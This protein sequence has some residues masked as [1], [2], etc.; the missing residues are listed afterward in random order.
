[1]KQPL[2]PAATLLLGSVWPAQAA[3][4]ALDNFNTRTVGNLAGQGTW[5][6]S[7]TTAGAVLVDPTNSINKIMR[8]S[9]QAGVGMPLPA[10]ITNSSTSATLFFRMRLNSTVNDTSFGLSDVAATNAGVNTFGNFEVQA[11]ASNINLRGRDAG[12]TVNSTLNFTSSNWYKIWLVVNNSTDSYRIFYKIDTAPAADPPT[13]FVATDGTFNFRN[14]VA[15]NSLV[16]LQFTSNSTST[17]LYFDDFYID[18]AAQNMD[19]PTFVANPD[20]DG[21]GLQDAWEIFYFGNLS[22]APGDDTEG[23]TGDGLTNLEEQAKGT[24][25]TLADTD[26]DGLSDGAEDHGTL[27]TAFGNAPTSPTNPDSDGDGLTD[28]QEI[29]GTL[30]TGFANA[31]SNPNAVD[32]D[33]DGISDYDETVYATNPSNV[34]STPKLYSLIGPAKRNGS[35]ELLGGVTGSVATAAHWDTDP[36]GDVDNWTLWPGIS[37]ATAG[38]TDDTQNPTNGIRRT[39][40]DINNAAYN[41]TTYQAKEGDVI[42]VTWDHLISS[43]GTGNHT[44][45]VVYDDGAGTIVQ[46]TPT[47]TVS[48]APGTVNKLIYKVPAGSPL[49]GKKIGVGIKAFANDQRIDNVVMT[50]V[51]GDSDGDGLADFWED[52]YFGNN[53]DNPTP[54]E[55]ALQNGSGDPDGDGYNN[56]AEETV[57]SA[58]NN[59]GSNPG[60]TDSDGLADEWEISNAGNLTTLSGGGADAD[61]DFATDEQEE[62]AHSNPLVAGDFPDTDSDGLNDGWETFYFGNLATGNVDSDSDG[63]SNSAEMLAGSSPTDPAWT[64]QKAVLKHRWSFTGNLNDSVGTSNAQ[65]VDADA[66]PATGGGSSL[67]ASSVTLA[68]GLSTQSDYIDL[69]ANLLQGKKTPVTIELWA[70]QNSVQNWGRIFD[71]NNNT[72]N[73]YLM[74]AWTAGVNPAADSVEWKDTTLFTRANTLAPYTLGTQY[75]IVMTIVPAVNTAGEMAAGSRVS[76]YAAPAGASSPLGLLQ[77]N[78]DVPHHLFTFNDLHNWLGRSIA[79]TDNT[80]NA[81]YDE[82]RIWDGALSSREA[83]TAQAAGPDAA[84]LTADT[85]GDTLPDA[86]EIAFFGNLSKTA[87]DDSDGDGSSNAAELAAGSLPNNPASKPGDADGDGLGDTW[88]FTNF[89]GFAAGP[90]DDPDGDRDSNL[91]EFTHGTNPLAKGDFYSSTGDTVPD[92][93]K[94][95]YGISGQT[96]DSDLDEG[97]GDGLN[98]LAE[99]NANT[100]PIDKDSDNDGRNDGDEVNG[101]IFSNVLLFD[102]DQDGLSDGQEI[103]LTTNPTV[104]DTDG[105]SFSDGYEVSHGGDPLSAASTPAQPNGFTLVEDFDGPG[106]VVGQTINGVNGWVASEPAKATVVADPADADHEAEWLSGTLTKQLGTNG[107]QIINGNTGTLF[108]QMYCDTNV[109]DRSFGLSDLAA[110]AGVGDYEAQMAPLAANIRVRNAAAFPDTGYDVP[111]QQWVNVWMVANNNSDTVKVYMDTPL[112]QTGKIELTSTGGPYVFRNGVATNALLSLLLMKFEAADTR[113]LIDNIYVDAKAE[114][115]ANPLGSAADSDSDG[116]DDTW[117]TTYFGGLTE[118]ATGDFDKDGTDNLT[119]FR[120]GLT[121]NDGKS[122]FNAK[123]ATNGAITWPSKTG[124]TFKIERS[125][126][127]GSGSWTTLQA[128]Y[129]GAAGTTSYTDPAPPVGKAFYRITLN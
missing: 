77:G 45:W 8:H 13:E 113:I 35:F 33:A 41:I 97:S 32:T 86:W 56:E 71:F 62:T 25:P 85:D 96:G 43:A 98:N 22:P 118:T 24:N 42:R 120:L 58:P 7:S 84:N 72:T 68:G 94:A 61:L 99:F 66:N 115:L 21:D 73:E 26:G 104:A 109:F 14:G 5:V 103:T 3:F 53:D 117:E 126:S 93:W 63:F 31:P 95:F 23:G 36:N 129:P 91:V 112:G 65:I 34:T 108:F 127:L 9:G 119:E 2:I 67:G 19:D 87:A 105:D 100:S 74:M 81:T 38:G 40:I 28:G 69:G 49:I 11:V 88:E 30:N 92:S 101:P 114:N 57:G 110:P 55:L 46:F 64:P 78:F 128:T 79:A 124:T 44:M 39:E 51:D 122:I 107:L 89:G 16:T 80:A 12:A 116:M 47:A 18:T 10:A 29:N 20:T 70:T 83:V 75:H 48:K 50:V 90:N 15:A 59:A 6:A 82:V 54:A 121:P 52:R 76:W 60:D 1:M 111:A 4:T 37:S 102:T 106:M 27:N 123:R 125:T 17:S